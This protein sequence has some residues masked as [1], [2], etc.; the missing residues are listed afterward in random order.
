MNIDCSTTTKIIQSAMNSHNYS[1]TGAL[2]FPWCTNGDVSPDW[3]LGIDKIC[4]KIYPLF[5]F[6]I[7]PN[8][9]YYSPQKSR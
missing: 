8:F 3:A 5:Y 1:A 4:F 2:P 7:P 9:T 6:I